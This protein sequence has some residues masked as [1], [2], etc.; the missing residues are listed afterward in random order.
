MGISGTRRTAKYPP[1]TPVRSLQ[2]ETQW[3]YGGRAG[4]WRLLRLFD[5]YQVKATFFA[6][7]MALEQNPPLGREITAQGHDVCGHGLRWVEQWHLDRDAEKESIHRAVVSIEKS[8]GR[9]P[10]GW[11]T[12]SGLVLIRARSWRKVSLRLRRFER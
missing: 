1:Q 5:Q 11:F 6:C 7:A 12:K 2:T 9:R 3:E 4:V 8:T 10:L